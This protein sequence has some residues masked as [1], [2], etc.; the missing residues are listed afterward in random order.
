MFVEFLVAHQHAIQVIL[1]ILVLEEIVMA[2][3]LCPALTLSLLV[4]CV[5][6]AEVNAVD[7]STELALSVLPCLLRVG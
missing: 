3:I 2:N 5:G 4:L 6:Q 1:L 7:Q